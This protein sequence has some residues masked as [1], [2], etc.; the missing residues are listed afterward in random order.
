MEI[1]AKTQGRVRKITLEN[2]MLL[3]T[4]MHNTSQEE[5]VTLK[6]GPVYVATTFFSN[7][8]PNDREIEKALDYIEVSSLSIKNLKTTIGQLFVAMQC[9]PKC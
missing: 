7:Q 3:F 6:A 1:A 9:L 4:R 5:V 8:Y 2:E